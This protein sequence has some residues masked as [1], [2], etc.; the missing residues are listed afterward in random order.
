M[1]TKLTL[2]VAMLTMALAGA[3]STALGDK[4]LAKRL[5]GTWVTD[6]LVVSGSGG[7]ESTRTYKADG[8]GTEVVQPGQQPR[9]A[10]IRVTFVWSITNSVLFVKGTVLTDPQKILEKTQVPVDH[11]AHIRF[12]E[13]YADYLLLEPV[14]AGG[15]I[16]GKGTVFRKNNA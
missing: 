16:M 9:S 4:E 10:A 2:L 13:R 7:W 1:R 6:P 3:D 11:R 8:T 15:K 14:D 5:L 12:S